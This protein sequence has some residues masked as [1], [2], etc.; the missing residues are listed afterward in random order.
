MKY[1]YE[2]DFEALIK[3]LNVFIS[4]RSFAYA[5]INILGKV[6]TDPKFFCACC[7]LYHWV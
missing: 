5:S 7:K 4:L 6:T 2:V 3:P 1:D